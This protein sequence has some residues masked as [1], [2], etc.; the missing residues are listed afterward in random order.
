MIKVAF[1]AALRLFG[2]SAIPQEITLKSL[3]VRASELF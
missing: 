1:E 2:Y 3:S